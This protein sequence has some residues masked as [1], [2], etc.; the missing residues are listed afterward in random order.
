MQKHI[1]LK[2]IKKRKQEITGQ[3]RVVGFS[4]SDVE[5]AA[6]SIAFNVCYT[7]KYCQE[8]S[9]TKAEPLNQSYICVRE[10]KI[11]LT[12]RD[13]EKTKQ[14]VRDLFIKFKKKSSK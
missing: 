14:E 5:M 10:F 2:F 12:D 6:E 1:G 3:I 4:R 13:L 8:L 11:D 9:R 7:L